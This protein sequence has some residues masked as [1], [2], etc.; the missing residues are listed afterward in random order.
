MSEASDRTLAALLALEDDSYTPL[1]GEALPTLYER[2]DLF[3]RAVH[4]LGRE[5]TLQ[6]QAAARVRILDAMAD[7]R[8][9]E[10]T[11]GLDGSAEDIVAAKV[12]SGTARVRIT[13]QRVMLSERITRFLESLLFPLVLAAGPRA[14]FAT[15]PLA[16]LMLAA[17][18]WSGAWFYGARKAENTVAIWSAKE[19]Q[20]GRTYQCG[21]RTIAGFPL[22]I[23]M[24]CTQPSVRVASNQSI[25]T[26][27]A[28]EIRAVANI[29]H[30]GILNV[31]IS[32]PVSVSEHNQPIFLGNWTLA[33]VIVHGGPS[34]ERV[35]LAI[36]RAQFYRATQISMQ[37]LL[38]SD[39]L[40]ADVRA[41]STSATGKTTFDIS[42][43]VAG[44]T[45]P[46]SA[47]LAS[48]PFV[49][50]ATAVVG[51]IATGSPK[52]FPSL[53]RAWQANGGSL[54]LKSVR[55][56]QGKALAVAMGDV[57]LNADGRVEGSLRLS[58]AGSYIQFAESVLRDAAQRNRT[59]ESMQ[60]LPQTRSLEAGG[61]A[62]TD[63]PS[64]VAVPP[65]SPSGVAIHFVDG[66]VYAGTVLLGVIPPLY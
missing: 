24:H 55:I 46:S 61:P 19:A 22:R 15:A 16:V 1:V 27:E 12:G 48:Q 37:P 7:S 49:A 57:G 35:F 23:E 4:G 51:G 54:E 59:A 6:E 11:K 56:Q 39:R 13:R 10:I 5:F 66:S 50:D 28:K 2:V 40:E 62:K 53:L 30:P 58:I 29:L 17:A 25:I 38:I 32:G 26:A 42:A 36:D 18:G 45:V 34:P 41:K 63:R 44:G 64:V 43:H 52:G 3:L 9:G 8:T 21:S 65:I 60:A 31:E 33:R 14:R 47:L 20:A